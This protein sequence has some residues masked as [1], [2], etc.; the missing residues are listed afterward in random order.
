MTHPERYRLHSQTLHEIRNGLLLAVLY[1]VGGK[2][3]LILALPPG[4]ASPI[5]PPAGIAVAA[6]FI[7]GRRTLPWI[8]LGSAVLN[9]WVGYSPENPF[10]GTSIAAAFIIALAS[11]LQAAA[12]GGAPETLHRLS[13]TFRHCQGCR[14]RSASV[15]CH[16]PGQFN[17]LGHWP[18]GARRP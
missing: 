17:A 15:A 10:H 7:G 2:L 1:I 3:S 6:V 14:P 13:L 12:G 5:F 18:N 9:L 8:F 4:Y 11:M 16:L